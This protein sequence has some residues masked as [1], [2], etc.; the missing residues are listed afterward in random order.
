MGALH[1]R[2]RRDRELVGAL[3]ALPLVGVAMDLGA[4][5]AAAHGADEASGELLLEEPPLARLLVRIPLQEVHERPPA[6][7]FMLAQ[8]ACMS[9][10][11]LFLRPLG[12]INASS[13]LCGSEATGIPAVMPEVLSHFEQLGVLTP[14]NILPVQLE[15]PWMESLSS[16]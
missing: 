14:S 4:G 3:R 8:P 11:H 1:H 2:P 9:L 6:L 16:A 12:C 7:A 13:S 15:T 10:C 5:G